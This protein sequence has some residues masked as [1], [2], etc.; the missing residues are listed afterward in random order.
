[1]RART[2]GGVLSAVVATFAIL[3]GVNV[4]IL[5][6]IVK[7]HVWLSTSDQL[8]GLF[9]AVCSKVDLDRAT[10]TS[11]EMKRDL[12]G[13]VCIV[14]G[15]NV[16]LGLETARG[17]VRNGCHTIVAGRRKDA[18][19][20]ACKQELVSAVQASGA[21]CEPM[22]LDLGSLESVRA[23]SKAFRQRFKRLDILVLNAG[24]TFWK[25]RE[26]TVDGLEQMFQVSCWQLLRNDEREAS[27]LTI[28]SR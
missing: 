18:I 21:T 8:I 12:H 28:I 17:L 11:E 16:G 13:Q 6:G 7:V 22:P 5:P 27:L 20:R 4:Q 23:F 24:V 25:E 19:E 2:K 9:P 26:L 15:A 3:S 1:M 14:T 10:L